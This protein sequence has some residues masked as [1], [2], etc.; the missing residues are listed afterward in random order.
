MGDMNAGGH[1]PSTVGGYAW[2]SLGSNIDP[3]NHLGLALSLLRDRFGR[4]TVSSVYRT[5]AVGF[6]GPDFLNLA[7]GIDSDLGPE[8][9]NA[10]LHALEERLG[11][12]RDV[13]RFSSRTL[14]IDIVLF[15]DR[16]M[17]GPGHLQLPREE[18]AK[19]AF[20]LGPMAQIAGDL[21]HPILGKSL[22]Q[23]WNEFP[24]ADKLGLVAVEPLE[25]VQ[26]G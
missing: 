1:R 25:P 19:Q 21:L 26:V 20:V 10:W 4:L 16:V 7:V 2:L 11:R 8:A 22:A 3:R 6:D 14:D 18:L 9:L 13:P 12:H 15:G 24:P 17:S 23:L 5:P